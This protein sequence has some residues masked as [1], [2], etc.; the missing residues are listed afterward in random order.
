MIEVIF[1]G[2]SVA[3]SACT[4]WIQ[5]TVLH[6]DFEEPSISDY[7]D[8]KGIYYLTTEK[9]AHPL[10]RRGIIVDLTVI[11]YSPNDIA[12]FDL[13]ATSN[14]WKNS[15]TPEVEH[16]ILTLKS[17]SYE[18]EI[19]SISLIEGTRV[20]PLNV[21]SDTSGVFKANSYT[22]FHL[23]LNM[24]LEERNENSKHTCKVQFKVA[25]HSNLWRRK[26]SQKFKC[27]DSHSFVISDIDTKFFNY[28]ERTKKNRKIVY[29]NLA[30]HGSPFSTN[31]ISKG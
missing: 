15:I 2:I 13:K 24:P 14:N 27:Y 7:I 26:K 18:H 9:D 19:E 28:G 6:V 1:S 10:N 31:T 29:A 12:F 4:L 16:E 22:M 3:I 11:N 21:P 30:D 25:K 5:R 23:F 8:K 20:Y 17:L